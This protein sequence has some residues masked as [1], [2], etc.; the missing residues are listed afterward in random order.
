MN[1]MR[2]IYAEM[3]NALK[4]FVKYNGWKMTDDEAISVSSMHEKWV[5][6]R[7]FE[8]DDVESVVSYKGKLYRIVSA[9]TAQAHFPP[10]GEG[11]FALYRPIVLGHEG[12]EDDPIPYT[13]GMDV[14]AGL[15]YT[16]KGSLWMAKKD[17]NPCVWP[18]A[19]GNE[20]EAVT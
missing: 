20:W 4:L 7:V 15:Y 13:Y 11:L 16:D 1:D 17:M 10:D 8:A 9:H 12:T 18:P 5:A 6:G 3:H 2:K 19:E 14:S